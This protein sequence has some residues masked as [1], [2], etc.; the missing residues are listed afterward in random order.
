M[1]LL[2]P[3]YSNKE[4]MA[5]KWISFLKSWRAKHKGVSLKDS[6]KKGSA[7]YKS[8]K[9]KSKADAKPKRKGKKKTYNAT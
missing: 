6:M 7:E 8:K 3:V 4:H 1:I 5:N 2:S 9:G